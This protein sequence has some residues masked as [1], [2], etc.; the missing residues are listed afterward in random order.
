LPA[1]AAEAPELPAGNLLGEPA[2]R[3]TAAAIGWAA[4]SLVRRDPDAV[5]CVVPAD[6]VLRPSEA[7]RA[8]VERAVDLLAREPWALVTF[9]VRPR[10]PHTG[11]GYVHLGDPVAGGPPIAWRAAGFHEKPDGATAERY[12][13]GGRHLWNSGLFC[14][15][16]EA[17]RE[18]LAEC[19]PQ[20]AAGV[21]A[22]C[23]R[24]GRDADYTAIPAAAVD[25]AVIEPSAA[26][27]RVRCVALEADWHDV[28]SY[29]SLSALLPADA[30]GNLIAADPVVPVAS[31]RNIVIA[32]A[33]HAVALIGLEDVIVVHT[34]DATLVCRKADA[35]R[36]RE[37]VEQLRGRGLDRF[38]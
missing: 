5:M 8:A 35:E 15:R 29:L 37:A 18:R 9:G 30:G 27:G 1:V 12:V 36:V 16:A 10:R 14:F 4:E 25:R 23:D 26:A 31:V 21:R 2:G 7:V 24:P 3:N 11:Y 17:F 28:G 6:H 32:P 33:G 38:L 20:I 22:W 13:A 19:A 34:P